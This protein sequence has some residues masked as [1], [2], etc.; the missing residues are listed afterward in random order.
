MGD[1]GLGIF[2]GLLGVESSYEELDLDED[3][4]GRR[5]VVVEERV[6]RVGLIHGDL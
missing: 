5:Q 3:G 6:R 2:D 1:V 4:V